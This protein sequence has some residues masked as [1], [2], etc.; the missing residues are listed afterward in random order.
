MKEIL[1]EKG[2]NVTEINHLI[3][4]ATTVITEKLNGTAECKIK[5]QRSKPTRGSDVYRGA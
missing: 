4:A 3:Y 5:A 1:E 2:L